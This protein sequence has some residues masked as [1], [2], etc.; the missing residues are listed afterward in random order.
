MGW[1]MRL[2]STAILPAPCTSRSELDQIGRAHERASGRIAV[3]VA[4]T[5]DVAERDGVDEG[6][7]AAW[8]GVVTGVVV[9]QQRRHLAHRLR[10]LRELLDGL[11]H[12]WCTRVPH[13]LPAPDLDG[14]GAPAA[15]AM[16]P[17][18]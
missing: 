17:T 16:L 11:H 9:G 14:S 5:Y 2:F 3:A 4:Y 18:H 10:Q 1:P 13:P 6:G 7:E 15:A 12:R 8:G